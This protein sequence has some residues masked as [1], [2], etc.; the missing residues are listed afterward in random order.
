ML[1]QVKRLIAS[2]VIDRIGSDGTAEIIGLISHDAYIISFDQIGI[3][4]DIESVEVSH[5]ESEQ[6]VELGIT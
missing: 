3:V 4:A 5:T 1:Q 6:I 2:A